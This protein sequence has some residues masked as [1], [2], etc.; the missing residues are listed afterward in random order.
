MEYILYCIFGVIVSIINWLFFVSKDTKNCVNICIALPLC[1]FL[2]PAV[3]IGWVYNASV[4]LSKKYI[5]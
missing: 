1:M 3:F 2:W 4:Y 5:S